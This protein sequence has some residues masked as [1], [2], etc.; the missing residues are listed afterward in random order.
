MTMTLQNDPGQR[1]LFSGIKW[2][3]FDVDGVMTDGGIILSADGNETKRFHSR[4]GHALK[5]LHRSG[6]KTAIITGRKSKVVEFR[7]KELGITELYQ[8][9]PEKLGVYQEILEKE[10]L[11]P[12]E[13]AFMG[14]DL[15]DLPILT[16]C[17]LPICPADAAPE[18]RKE[19]LFVTPSGGGRGAVREAVEYFLKGAGLW[20]PVV[21]RYLS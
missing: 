19:C 6:V 13:T 11:K 5:L 2:F 21:K 12:S 10:G 1:P 8:N 3:G 7:A 14:D 17:A 4:D 20:A 15:V 18:V 16:R 9:F